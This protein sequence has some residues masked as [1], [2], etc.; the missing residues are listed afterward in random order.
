MP[1]VRSTC[2]VRGAIVGA[3]VPMAYAEVAVNA[4]APIRQTFTYRVPD[5]MA[6]RVG[7]TVYVPFGSRRLQ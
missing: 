4:A 5:G 7:H 6:L 1:P 3:E 2:S